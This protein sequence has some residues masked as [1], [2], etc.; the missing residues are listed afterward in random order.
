MANEVLLG[1]TVILLFGYWMTTFLFANRFGT[2]PDNI[3]I[4]LDYFGISY[5]AISILVLFVLILWYEI[6]IRQC[7]KAFNAKA[8]PDPAILK[9][10]RRRVLNEPY[11]IALIDSVIWLLGTVLFRYLGSTSGILIGIGSG[12]ITV[13][14]VFLW[15]EHS[16]QHTRIPLFFPEGDLS[17]VRGVGSTSIR[18][19]I[20]ALIFAVSLVPL[21]TILM[22]V[23]RFR[24][25]RMMDDI[26]LLNLIQHLE[27]TVITESIV[28]LADAILLS[29]LVIHHLRQ[30]V[31]EI[32]LAMDHVKK[33][34]YTQKARVYTNDEIG[35]AAETLNDMSK[36][37]QERERLQKSIYIAQE[38][39]QLLLPKSNPDVPGLD[40]AGKS[41]YCEE[42]GGDYYD[43][44]QLGSE[45]SAKTGVIVGD[46]SG[47]G[48]GSALFMSSA[49]SL[50]RLRSNHTD[51]L[52]EIV[53]DVNRELSNDFGDSGQFMTLFYLVIDPSLR[54][55]KW[56]RAGHDPAM[57]YN[58][59]NNTFDELRGSG[60]PIGV[61]C[62][63]RYEEKEKQSLSKDQIILIGTDGIWEAQNTAGKMFGKEPIYDMIRKNADKTSKQI[64][65]GIVNELEH[66]QR[67]DS[68]VDDVTLVVVKI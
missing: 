22:T 38:V 51:N 34:N 4:L 19:R 1:N 27:K 3:Q 26:T 37:L 35:L 60:L 56:V 25:M 9:K 55:L 57:L 31:E 2:P 46:V 58:P 50:L 12:F 49:R 63:W 33:G 21:A 53:N 40:V 66:F 64:L 48:I 24:Q 13:A 6:P 28:F 23:Y 41:I 20:A 10:A 15:L 42:T 62:D 8:E 59:R 36:G 14:F 5:R 61:D 39:Q 43:F 45:E 16:A 29:V 47:H 18:K 7:L 52:S 67:G 11:W 32:I 17:R 30:P 54:S 65:E 44:L 68:L